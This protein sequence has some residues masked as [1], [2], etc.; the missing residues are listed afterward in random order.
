MPLAEALVALLFAVALLAWG[1]RAIG[2][3]YPIVQ[4]L[5]GL[6]ITFVP[7]APD[8]TL[9]PEVI[10]LIFVPPLVH[11]AAYNAGHKRL[12]D[13]APELTLLAVAL[14]AATVGAAAWVAHGLVDGMTWP[15]ASGCTCASASAA[16]TS[17]TNG[18][19]RPATPAITEE[20]RP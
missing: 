9:D 2:V 11:A 14:V 3:P 15:A 19:P 4:V 7:G 18:V 8:I 6:A 20:A 5:G 13:R 17:I 12:R 10:F 1:A 16:G